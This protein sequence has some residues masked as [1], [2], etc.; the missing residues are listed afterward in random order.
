MKL[1][2]YLPSQNAWKVRLLLNHLGIEYDTVPVSIF[3]GEGQQPEF[4][5]R[6]PVG[7]VPVLELDDGRTLAESNA[8]LIYLAEG[9]PYLPE[10]SWERAQVARWMF[11]EEDYIQNGI[12][13]LRHWTMTGKIRN[14]SEQIIAQKRAIG[15]KTLR[16][17]N[18]WLSEHDFLAAGRYTIADMAV[19]AYTAFAD[20]AG[21]RLEDFPAVMRW[22]E[23]V[24]AQ[25]GFLATVHTYSIDPHSA[26][27]LP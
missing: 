24:R 20:E 5:A 26:N 15:M 17:L 21:L 16:I 4:L 10:D 11:F 2:D 12:A 27:E 1:Y 25:P 9:T 3:E 13:S 14:R 18:H 22:I 8:I 7:A 23:R 19:F 6:N